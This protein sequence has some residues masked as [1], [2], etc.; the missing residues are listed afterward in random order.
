MKR[1]LEQLEANTRR[2]PAPEHIEVPLRAYLEAAIA[3]QRGHHT[4]PSD[5]VPVVRLELIQRFTEAAAATAD[6][7]EADMLRNR[8]TQLEAWTQA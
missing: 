2:R 5:Q 7:E 1:R 6:R 8:A 4:I 3:L